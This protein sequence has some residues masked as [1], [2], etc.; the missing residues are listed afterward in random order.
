MMHVPGHE[1]DT[2]QVPHGVVAQL[3]HESAAVQP[4]AAVQGCAGV[5]ITRSSPGSWNALIVP[6]AASAGTTLNDST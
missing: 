3:K 2:T 1:Q 5:A 4:A 6:A